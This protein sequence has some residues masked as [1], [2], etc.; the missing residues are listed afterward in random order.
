MA[1]SKKIVLKKQQ[2]RN[3]E[4]YNVQEIQDRFYS[5]SKQKYVFQDLIS[6]IIEKGNILVAYRNIKSNAGSKTPGVNRYTIEDVEKYELH[7]WVSY[8]RKRFENFSPMPIRRVEIEKD[9]GR[10]RPLGIPTIEDRVIQQCIK[11]ILEPIVEAKFYHGSYG[12][13]PDRGTKNAIA[14]VYQLVN[15]NKLHY[16]VDI[17]IKSFFDNVDHGKLLKQI[18]TI[19][20]RDKKLISIISSMM[21]AEIEGI[22][23]PQKGVPQGGILSPLLSNIVLNELD[24]WISSQWETMK[25]KNYSNIGSKIKA[26]KKSNLKEM[27]IVRYCDDFKILTRDVKSAQKIY[28][29]VSNWLKERLSLD[30]N[31]EKSQIINLRK[32]Y[33]NF[34]GIKIKAI[35]KAKGYVV[36]SRISDKANKKIKEKIRNQIE[37]IR[38]KCTINNVARLNS[39]I[40]GWHN[41]YSMATLVNIDFREI[42]FLVR[43]RLFNRTRSIRSDKLSESKTY[44]RLYG[45]YNFKTTSICNITIYPLAGINFRIPKLIK[46]QASRYTIEGRYFIHKNLAPEFKEDIKFLI[47][48][49]IKNE[50]MEKN[51]NRISL[52]VGQKG[53]C[54]ISKQ[55]LKLTEMVIRNKLPKNKGGTDKY[56]NLILVNKEISVLIDEKDTNNINQ[57]KEGI[58][59]GKKALDKLNALRILVGNPMI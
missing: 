39:M 11:Q 48:N 10:K 33:S 25:T 27:Y 6:R 42:K 14:R 55:K 43:K 2:L 12:F 17:D 47:D 46:N 32:N 5:Q 36:R 40:L 52:Y 59:L 37:E 30:V 49:P 45:K 31:K 56:H 41:Y 50:S 54:H 23:I 1:A 26:L 24:W 13:R 19:G 38:K 20:I 21:K 58:M 7:K 22:G 51:D 4:Y 18:W 9:D 15:I 16:A 44:K 28:V 8:I 29:A 34:L 57:C 53:L 35:K 3:N